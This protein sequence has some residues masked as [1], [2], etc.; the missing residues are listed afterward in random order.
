MRLDIHYAFEGFNLN[1]YIIAM[2][3]DLNK[4]VVLLNSSWEDDKIYALLLSLVHLFDNRRVDGLSQLE[5]H[6]STNFAK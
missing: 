5:T 6:E 1:T 2:D 4:V 3:V